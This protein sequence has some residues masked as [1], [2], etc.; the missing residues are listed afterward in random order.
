MASLIYDAES[1]QPVNGVAV[2]AVD[3]DGNGK[4]TNEE[5]DAVGNLD[6]LTA[7]F[8]THSTSAA[9]VGTID[10]HT[11]NANLRNFINW[12]RSEGQNILAH[13]GLLKAARQL[14]LEK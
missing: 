8:A 6:A 7:F 14:A 10:I 5:R 3:L 2:L 1:R 11:E 12:T 13:F 9:P 4:I